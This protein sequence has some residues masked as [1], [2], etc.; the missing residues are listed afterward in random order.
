MP[1]AKG[2]RKG[3]ITGSVNVPYSE[4]VDHGCL[5]SD[6]EL[7]AIFESR[8][9]DLKKKTVFSCGSGV[10][11]CIAE[12]A[13]T[14]CGGS[15][16]YIYDGSWSEYVSR[17]PFLVRTHN[18]VWCLFRGGIKSQNSRKGNKCQIRPQRCE[19]PKFEIL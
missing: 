11:A 7:K 12:L 16:G 18:L 2:L 4:L 17:S 14:L 6:E 8:G 10:A 15:E 9:L 13:W 5:K 3:H 19:I 1:E